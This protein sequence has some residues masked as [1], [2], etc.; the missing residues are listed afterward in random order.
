MIN[1][2]EGSAPSSDAFFAAYIP[3]VSMG[4]KGNEGYGL[5]NP[6]E[7]IPGIVDARGKYKL[8]CKSKFHESLI[9]PKLPESLPVFNVDT[10]SP[11]VATE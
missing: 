4:G 2:R 3:H 1:P 6:L 8:G 11:K 9:L 10:D 7:G 5:T